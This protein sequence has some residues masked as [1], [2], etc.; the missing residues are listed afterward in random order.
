MTGAGANYPD[1][2]IWHSRLATLEVMGL[3]I[4]AVLLVR[5][6]PMSR[7]R[8][9][10]GDVYAGGA[11]DMPVVTADG[12]RHAT[13]VARRVVRAAHRLPREPKCLA[14]AMALQWL[15]RRGGFHPQLVLAMDRQ[16]RSAE[17]GYHAWVELGGTMLIG[18][19]D[20]DNFH[21]V[22]G[23]IPAAPCPLDHISTSAPHAR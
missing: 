8:S 17:H 21:I 11:G 22:L 2:N 3:L 20:R 9:S 18:N 12:M 10:L 14:Q 6:A 13:A 16:D 23:F 15:L 4:L 19:C 7:W 5:L 1:Q